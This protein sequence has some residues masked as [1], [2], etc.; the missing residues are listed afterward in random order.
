MKTCMYV[1][2]SM[3]AWMGANRIANKAHIFYCPP[4]WRSHWGGGG[5]IEML[6]I[7]PCVPQSVRPSQSLLAR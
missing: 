2:T 6:G 7:C 4:P 5:D 3:L 1:I